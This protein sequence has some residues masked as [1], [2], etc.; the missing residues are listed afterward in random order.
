VEAL[1]LL[2]SQEGEAIKKLLYDNGIYN[3]AK[4]CK[5]IGTQSSNYHNIL[6]GNRSCSITALNKIL[7]G[8][9][10]EVLSST[11]IRIQPINPGE[12][13]PDVYSNMDEEES[14]SDTTESEP[15]EMKAPPESS[16][17]ERLLEQQKTSQECHFRVIQDES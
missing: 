2:T 9:G 7:S 6:S 4:Y 3:H 17:L 11:T 10:Y 5:K 15:T 8:I 13:V 12:P 1:L 14:A 16:L